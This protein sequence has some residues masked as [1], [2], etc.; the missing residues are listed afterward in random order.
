MLVE[1]FW[2]IPLVNVVSDTDGLGPYVFKPFVYFRL[3]EK[4]LVSTA[5]PFFTYS[6][7]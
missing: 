6:S 3:E 5:S 4:G 2:Y 1:F 7:R